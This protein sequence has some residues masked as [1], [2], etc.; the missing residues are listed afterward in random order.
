MRALDLHGWPA[1]STAC[2]MRRI[3]GARRPARGPAP[4]RL[5]A[6]AGDLGRPHPWASVTKLCTAMAVLVAVE[7]G[8]VSLE[9][10]AGPPGSTVAHLMSHASGL[11]PDSRDAV[12][13][14]GTRR[15]Y[16]NAG[17]EVLGEH[18]ER[19]ASMRCDEYVT[20]AVL[21]PLGME[22]AQLARGASPASG[23]TGT[24]EDLAALARELLAPRIVSK[25]TLSLATRPAFPGLAGVL[26]GFGFQDPCDWGLGFEIKDAKDPHWTGRR[27]SSATFGHFGRSG[28][29]LWVDPEAGVSCAG[30]SD[31]AF[32]PWAQA[33]WPALADAV[34]ETVGPRPLADPRRAALRAH[35][36][37]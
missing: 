18:L 34:M 14:P 23:M 8:T 30:L 35:D 27:C 29:F 11:A 6:A 7:E 5:E 20:E 36:G 21:R 19:R 10:R 25:E 15:I 17:F 33:A 31:R 13:A 26:P 37:G 24:A 3:D 22:G 32:G 2:V 28:S 1:G 9:D 16:S 12:A 4:V